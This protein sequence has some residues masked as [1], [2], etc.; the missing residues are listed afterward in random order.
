LGALRSQI[1]A[2]GPITTAWIG[3]ATKRIVGALKNEDLP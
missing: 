3:S 1:H 2:H